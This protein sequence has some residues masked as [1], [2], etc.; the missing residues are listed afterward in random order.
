MTAYSIYT[1]RVTNWP[2]VL[3]SAALLVPL[4]IGGASADGSP[5]DLALPILTAAVIVLL[6]VLTGVSIRTAAGPNGVAIRFGPAA[7]PRCSYPLDRIASAE[8]V[9][10]G[11]RQVAFGFWWTPWHTYCTVRS[12]PALRLNLTSG[13]RVTVT[14]PDAR[15]AAAALQE[16]ALRGRQ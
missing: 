16:A 13:R 10:I 4:L 5:R 3:V 9:E 6:N 14:V 1:G 11:L 8:V 2:I 12:G 15:A 7:W